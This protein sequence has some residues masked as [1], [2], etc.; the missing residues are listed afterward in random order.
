MSKRRA[1]NHRPHLQ[2][3]KRPPERP[4]PKPCTWFATTPTSSC[5]R[6]GYVR[7]YEAVL[8]DVHYAASTQDPEDWDD[9][10]RRVK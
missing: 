10:V 4:A 8:C 6:P 5:Q 7:E 2:R 1:P 9:E 3:T